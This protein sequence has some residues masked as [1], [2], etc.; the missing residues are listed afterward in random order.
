MDSGA[1][2]SDE[3]LTGAEPRASSPPRS[4]RADD[5][6]HDLADNRLAPL[7]DALLTLRPAATA[8]NSLSLQDS[9]STLGRARTWLD[10]AQ[11]LTRGRWQPVPPPTGDARA[12]FRND[13]ALLGRLTVEDARLVWQPADA[14]GSAWAAPLPPD[15]A[16]RLRAGLEAWSAPAA[17]GR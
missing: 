2:R 12:V 8:R 11:T 16:P 13:G 4:D 5:L 1:L 3:S 17:P 15:A 9:G 14:P 7:R 6:A 10:D